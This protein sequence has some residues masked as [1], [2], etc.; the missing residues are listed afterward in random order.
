[1]TSSRPRAGRLRLQ[2][3]C[4]TAESTELRTAA[5]LAG[6][7]LSAYLR[8][9]GLSRAR[10]GAPETPAAIRALRERVAALDGLVADLPNA[11]DAVSD[12]LGTDPAADH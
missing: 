12:L 7:D 11:I 4:T 9:T 6:L 3:V 10:R 1:M 5:N 8:E 2:V